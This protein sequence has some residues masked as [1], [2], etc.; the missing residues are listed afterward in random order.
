[1]KFID[2]RDFAIRLFG[3]NPDGT[4][5][6]DLPTGASFPFEGYENETQ[7]DVAVTIGLRNNLLLMSDWRVLPD[8][9][10]SDE[11][12]AAW[13][14]FR[15]VLRDLPSNPNWPDVQFPV[16]PDAEV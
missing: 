16:P 12:K 15:Q 9:P 4:C 5:L 2:K 6:F 1:M 8:S 10:T 13:V 11:D 7:W 14:E 3:V